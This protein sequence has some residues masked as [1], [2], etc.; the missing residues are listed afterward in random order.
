MSEYA[1]SGGHATVPAVPAGA[2][3]VPGTPVQTELHIIVATYA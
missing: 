1:A 3:H 2:E